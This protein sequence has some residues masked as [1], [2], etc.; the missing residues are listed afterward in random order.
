MK[1]VA[2]Y[3][4]RE[5]CEMKLRQ[6]VLGWFLYTQI[7]YRLWITS[8]SMYNLP[9]FQSY[10]QH[11]RRNFLLFP[12]VFQRGSCCVYHHTAAWTG[13]LVYPLKES[14][15]L[16][17]LTGLQKFAYLK[18]DNPHAS[19]VEYPSVYKHR[20]NIACAEQTPAFDPFATGCK[21][22]VVRKKVAL[23]L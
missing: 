11:E 1:G 13:W 22:F 12:D 23:R 10:F 19:M 4:P 6:I 18:I 16:I 15:L 14:W 3:S 2:C 9:R 8:N 7:R 17:Q 20:Q 21:C 5:G